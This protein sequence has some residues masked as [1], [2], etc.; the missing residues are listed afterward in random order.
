MKILVV[1]DLYPIKDDEK[2]T[3]KTIK[4][5]VD[6]WEKLDQEVRVIKPNFLFNSFLRR[7]PFYKSAIY[8]KVENINYFLP[9]VGN[10][11]RK[12]K[13]NKNTS[14]SG[15]VFSV[16]H[17]PDQSRCDINYWYAGRSTRSY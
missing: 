1:T 15:G 12:I 7:K 4:D 14:K 2:F 6:G 17:N 16:H 3:P 8:G 10:I 5:F 9:F 11:K 13:K